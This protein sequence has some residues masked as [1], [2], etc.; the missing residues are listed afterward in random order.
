MTTMS[1]TAEKTFEAN[2]QRALAAVLLAE[3]LDRQLQAVWANLT[4]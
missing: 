3:K 2:Y 4:S 1:G